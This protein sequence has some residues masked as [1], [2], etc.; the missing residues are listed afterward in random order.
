MEQVT[1]RVTR[2]AIGESKR[3]VLATVRLTNYHS[4]EDVTPF[5]RE[6]SA[7]MNALQTAYSSHSTHDGDIQITS[8]GIIEHLN[9]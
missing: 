7:V 8:A 6:C 3:E 2:D 5:N 4:G 1:I 9:S